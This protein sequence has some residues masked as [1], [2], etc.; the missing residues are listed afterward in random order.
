M[1]TNNLIRTC[2]LFIYESNIRELSCWS[3]IGIVCF[4]F[5][6]PQG[7]TELVFVLTDVFP[8]RKHASVLQ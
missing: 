4:L 7:N 8:V 6:F 2:V 1:Y 3:V 5:F